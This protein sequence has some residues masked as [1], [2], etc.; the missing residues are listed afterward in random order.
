[1]STPDLAAQAAAPLVVTGSSGF[2]GRALMG[3]WGQYARGLSLRDQAQDWTAALAGAR[4]V[5]HLAARVHVMRDKDP[6]PLAA[7]RQ[8]NVQTSVRLAQCAADAGVRRLVF[9]S[10]VKVMGEHSAPD[11]PFKES[12]TPQPDDAYGHSKWEAEQ[13]LTKLCSARGLE[14]VI[15]RAPLV[16]GPGVKA[17]F[18]ALLRAVYAGWPLPLGAV[19][20]RRSLLS[21][22]NLID[23]I[24]LCCHHRQAANQTFLVSDGHDVSTAQLLG[25][26]AQALGRR[27]RTFSV[28]VPLLRLAGGLLGRRAALERLCGNLQ[29]DIAKARKL[30]DWE[31]PQSIDEGLLKAVSAL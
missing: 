17:N 3:H 5:V 22:D 30:L 28:P 16:Y 4:T 19:D 2:V 26:M 25:H 7:F 9:L 8:V 31:P 21:L 12:D 20:N 18:A 14:L 6:D 24:T 27:S 29:V 11:R 1:M 10:S 13:A 15:I 23:F